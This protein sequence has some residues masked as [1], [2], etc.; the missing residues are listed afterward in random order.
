MKQILISL[1]AVA[2]LAS[3]SKSEEAAP[4][5]DGVIRIFTGVENDGTKAIVNAASGMTEAAFVRKDAAVSPSA[6]FSGG[7]VYK[8]SVAAST[9][10][11]AFSGSAPSYDQVDDHNA[12]F[13]AYYPANELISNV[14][15]WP[16]DGHT[17]IMVTD[18]IWDAGK[19]SAPLTG[20][21][22]AKLNFNHQLSQVEVV[23]KAESG[24][25]LSVVK[26]AWGQIAKI[27]FLAAPTTMTYTLTSAPT[28]ATSGSAAFEMLKSYDDADNAF[29]A[30]D[31][32]ANT[33]AAVNAVAM[34]APVAPTADE[35]FK[36]KVYTTG[37]AGGSTIE[38]EVPVVL[39]GA[40]SDTKPAMVKG[41]THKVTLTFNADAS[42][43]AVSTSTIDDWQDGATG[44]SGLVK[45]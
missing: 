17:D 2:A 5:N 42:N 27:E 23:C 39:S 33:N 4:V 21:S 34:L 41:Q 35:S 24:A 1:L 10:Q 38:V 13:V 40:V 31:I 3:C 6:D 12:W 32:P 44:D 7:T 14:V 25:A 28:V 11:V 29:A 26:A 45:P 22:G 8:G 20:A 19:Y 16:I 43:I 9:G 30:I 15:T 37:P 36:L 18:L